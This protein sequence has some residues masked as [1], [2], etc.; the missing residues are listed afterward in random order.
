[1]AE[2]RLIGYENRALAREDFGNDRVDAGEIGAGHSVTAI[3]E[4]DLAGSRGERLGAGRYQRER[5][6]KG[7]LANELAMVRVRYRLPDSATSALVEAPVLKSAMIGDIAQ[8]SERYRFAAAVAGFGQLLRGG[9]Y[10]GTFGYN[11]VLALARGARGDD[12]YGYR[13]EFLQLVNLAASL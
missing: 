1:M 4:V 3:Y 10:T 7:G 12:A 5:G 13:G 6:G 8:T 11:D 2:Y 9:K